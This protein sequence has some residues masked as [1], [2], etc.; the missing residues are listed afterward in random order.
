[1]GSLISVIPVWGV[2]AW[3]FERFDGAQ[4]PHRCAGRLCAAVQIRFDA[5]RRRLG[6]VLHQQDFVQDG[7]LVP[8]RD[9][10][11][12]IRDGL[13]DKR[14]MR[15]GTL[16]QHAEGCNRVY[17]PIFSCK[18]NPQRYFKGAWYAVQGDCCGRTNG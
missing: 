12:R 17:V 5:A 8:E 18:I 9:L 11:E 14:G 13:S 10:H 4:H 15:G 1:M 16:Q 3:F 6:F 7:E 2:C